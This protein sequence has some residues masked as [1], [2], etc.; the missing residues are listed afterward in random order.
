VRRLAR[1]GVAVRE[2]ARR[3]FG[4][5]RLRGRVERIIKQDRDDGEAGSGSRVADVAEVE[6]SELSGHELVRLLLQRRLAWLAESGKAPPARELRDLLEV[7]RR[8]QAVEAL[9][10]LRQL[11]SG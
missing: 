4:D 10:Q 2:I 9:E 3:V 1:E 5:V 11:G 7:E 6:V 8:L